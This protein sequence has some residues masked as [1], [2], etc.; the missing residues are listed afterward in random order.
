MKPIKFDLKLN[1]GTPLR[2]LSDLQENL[3][4]AVFEHFYTGKLAKWL[5]VC[6]LE[7]L[8]EKV[9]VLRAQHLVDK[10]EL[11]VKLFKE[12]CEIFVSEVIEKD[13][14]EAMQDYQPATF[15]QDSNDE[16]VE[17]FKIEIEELKA[18]IETL[19]FEVKKYKS[20]NDFFSRNVKE[21]RNM[22]KLFGYSK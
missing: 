1:D 13:A 17:Q 16:E 5:R 12:L 3:S 11:D 2:T 22:Q 18:E 19:Q 10:N 9:E 8:V 20:L 6:K 4:P 15:E 7:D 14:R 21:N